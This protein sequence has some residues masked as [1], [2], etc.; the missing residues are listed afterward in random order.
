MG[1]RLGNRNYT[2]GQRGRERKGEKGKAAEKDEETYP[3]RGESRGENI[4]S[5]LSGGSHLVKFSHHLGSLHVPQTASQQRGTVHK[6]RGEE[7]RRGVRHVTPLSVLCL[8][9]GGDVSF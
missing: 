8:S 4:I 3:E 7:E 2:S 1:E 9:R 6:R 5:A